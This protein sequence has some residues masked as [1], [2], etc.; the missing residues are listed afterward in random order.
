MTAM[1]IFDDYAPPQAPDLRSLIFPTIAD[2]QGALPNHRNVNELDPCGADW[3]DQIAPHGHWRLK[4]IRVLKEMRPSPRS[5][6]IEAIEAR[7]DAVATIPAAWKAI[8]Q[9]PAPVD[10]EKTT[11]NPWDEELGSDRVRELYDD[12]KGVSFQKAALVYWLLVRHVQCY[13]RKD[14]AEVFAHLRIAPLIYTVDGFS[15]TFFSNLDHEVKK[16]IAKI[17]GGQSLQTLER[18]PRS[19]VTFCAADTL[20]GALSPDFPTIAGVKLANNRTRICQTQHIACH[21]VRQSMPR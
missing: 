1:S 19:N 12:K 11:A 5:K 20:H 16:Q 9:V 10:P 7:R 13:L 3:E 17:A 6:F 15:D 4:C 18:F 8:C 2:L 21:H 14:P